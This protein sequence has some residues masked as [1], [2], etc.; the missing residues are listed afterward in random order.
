MQVPTT[1]AL[2]YNL[3]SMATEFKPYEMKA[4]E[5]KRFGMETHRE[6]PPA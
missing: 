2:V 1:A 4:E 5:K 3:H 6:T